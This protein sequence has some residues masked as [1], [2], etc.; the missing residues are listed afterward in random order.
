[1]KLSK[2]TLAVATVFSAGASSATFAID[3]YVDT[4]TKQIYAE[5]GPHRQLMGSFER[6][7][8]KAAKPAES[9]ELAKVQ[10]DLE[11]K[12]NEIKALQEHMT[13]AEQ[14]K[15]KLDKKGLNFETADKNFKFKLGGRIHADANYTSGDKYRDGETFVE[16]N[17]GTEIRRARMRFE[18]VFYNDWLFRIEPDFADDNVRVKDAFLQYTGLNWLTITGGQQKQNFSRE[19]QE[20]SNDMM[21]TERSLM[22]ILNAPTVDR[23]IGLNFESTGKNWVAKAGIYGDSI[24]PARTGTAPEVENVADEGWGISSRLIYNP[25]LEKTKLV[26]LGV[27]GNY[28]TP[29][30]TGDVAKGRALALTY[31]TNNMSN[32]DLVNTTVRDVD[33]IKM[34][35]LEA[36]G[37][38]GPL[39]V[40]AEYTRTWIDRKQKGTT[41]NSGDN[42]L[43]LDGWYAEAAWTLTGESRSYKEGNFR[44]LEPA[45]PFSLKNGGWGAWELATRYST[46]DLNDGGF[47]GGELS[48]VTVA[49]NWYFNSNFRL[50]ANYTRVLDIERADVTTPTG[51]ALTGDNGGLDTFT[52]RAQ[53]AF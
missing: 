26:H 18:G 5:P 40:G 8:D 44:Y 33:N 1:M 9:A 38:Y 31:E 11:L 45:K 24:T 19:L 23:A 20:S 30:A 10:E 41:I 15:V 13:E 7:E 28:R 3:L 14:V 21:F 47:Q 6:V 43:E 34:L 51:Q 39:S 32:L 4:K 42:N 35:G 52:L 2:L 27:A 22:N 46:A 50:L 12:T 37:L 36:A 48:N 53:V 17:D 16:A 25:I 29:D 49:L